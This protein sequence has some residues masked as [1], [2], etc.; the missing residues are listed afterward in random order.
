MARKLA[1]V[2]IAIQLQIAIALPYPLAN[3]QIETS[4]VSPEASQAPHASPNQRPQ[5]HDKRSPYF[6]PEEV[7]DQYELE[8]ML[9]ETALREAGFV[10]SSKPGSKSITKDHKLL[11]KLQKSFPHSDAKIDTTAAS[12]RLDMYTPPDV[13]PEKHSQS[14]SRGAEALMAYESDEYHIFWPPVGFF[15]IGAA[16]VCFCTILRGLRSK[17]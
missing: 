14:L 16:F 11:S 13:R 17:K 2:L 15:F 8:A 1:L 10:P 6:F 4:I 3:N 9:K 7:P 5:L 12:V